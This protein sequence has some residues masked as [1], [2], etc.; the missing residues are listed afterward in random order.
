MGHMAG[1]GVEATV[2]NHYRNIDRSHIQFD[3][4]IDD[5]STCV[6]KKEIEELGG[7]IFVV[8]QYTKIFKYY[9][10][11][12]QLFLKEKPLIV[13]SNLNTLSVFPLRAAK[14]AGVPIRIAHSHSTANPSETAKTLI[15]NILKP[16]SRVYP[17]HLAACSKHSAYWLFGDEPVRSDKVHII[18]NAVDIDKLIFNK[19]T[20]KKLRDSLKITENQ[21]VVGQV[22]RICYQK[23]Q[24]FTVEIFAEVL[25][26]RP[27]ALLIFAGD[28]EMRE[29]V[30]AKAHTLG[31]EE[32]VHFLGQCDDISDWYQAFD[33]LAFPSQYE[34]LPLVSVEAQVADLQVLA[35]LEVP[36]EAAIVPER[37]QFLTTQ[38]KTKWIQ[39]LSE[40]RVT[41]TR[42]NR[43]AAT[44][45]AGYDIERS[46]A[47]LCNWYEQLATQ[48]RDK[49][50]A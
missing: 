50:G 2:M 27:N 10:A 22:G 46:S 28:G 49:H 40:A 43:M 31:I 3:F 14:K 7:R 9:N 24:L 33:V 44:R 17:T 23:N 26:K 11:C 30:Q 18:K 19:G 42:M 8:P 29:T 21:L 35:S 37:I 1:G 6:P 47:E 12:E 15:K 34:G 38:D 4:V 41:P 16:F 32:S 25:K 13:H 20:R 5:D 48:E 39:C 36:R 45:M